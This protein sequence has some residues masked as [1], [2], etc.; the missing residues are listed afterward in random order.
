MLHSVA[1]LVLAHSA[2]LASL[3]VGAC[4]AQ[5]CGGAP[6][7]LLPFKLEDY[8]RG[9][10]AGTAR[11]LQT[12]LLQLENDTSRHQGVETDSGHLSWED[13]DF[14][15]SGNDTDPWGGGVGQQ[16]DET[17]GKGSASNALP[18]E[19]RGLREEAKGAGVL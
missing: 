10:E 18:D 3:A 12:S 11:R 4:G 2:A 15:G 9:V 6:Q 19:A 7:D 16:R 1:L 17:E 13:G 14:W 5:V 8:M